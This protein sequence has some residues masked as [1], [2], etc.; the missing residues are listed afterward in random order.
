MVLA[1]LDLLT[2]RP[3]VQRPSLMF[4]LNGT[5]LLHRGVVGADLLQEGLGVD[6]FQLARQLLQ[7]V[8][9]HLG[10]LLDAVLVAQ[11]L[12]DLLVEDLPG[13]IA[14]LLQHH[15]AVFGIG[16]V[17]EIGALIEEPLAVGVDQHA[18]GIAVLLEGVA[19]RQVAD[20]PAR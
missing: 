12:G 8:G 17:A 5:S 1:Q 19:D 10:H 6:A 9:A 13:E 15:A 18:P 4:G 7:R 14:R 11:L 3:S 2:A 20:I 16:V